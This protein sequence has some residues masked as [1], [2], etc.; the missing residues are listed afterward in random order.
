MIQLD[1][2]GDMKAVLRDLGKLPDRVIRPAAARAINDAARAVVTHVK[3]DS[4]SDVP[5]VAET[6]KTQYGSTNI[7]QKDMNRI[8]VGAKKR[9]RATKR[10]LSAAM[11]IKERDINAAK[12]AIGAG[13][14]SGVA[15][16]RAAV[17][18]VKVK[19]AVIPDS[20]AF[21]PGYSTSKTGRTFPGGII[22]KRRTGAPYPTEAIKIRVWP[23]AMSAMLRLRETI[24]RQTFVKVFEREA[25]RLSQLKMAA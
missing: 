19:G 1:I 7:K 14:F 15:G 2:R 25:A 23:K 20:W 6:T 5:I 11:Y 12:Y 18:G 9:G 16:K 10:R 21:G 3:R 4:A 22:L 8:V 13:G 17:R 24:G